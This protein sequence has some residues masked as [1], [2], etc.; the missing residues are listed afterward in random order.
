MNAVD[1]DG[2][3]RDGAGLAEVTGL[4]P[5]RVLDDSAGTRVIVRR[6]RSL[7]GAQLDLIE[8]RGG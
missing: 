8:T 1:A 7:P 2:G 5:A 3:H 4:L 6:E